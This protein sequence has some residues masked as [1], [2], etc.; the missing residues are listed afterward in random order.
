M[1]ELLIKTTATSYDTDD[2]VVIML[3]GHQWGTE[4]LN[5]AKFRTVS[6][7]LTERDISL[8][9]TMDTGFKNIS[10]I[11]Q[12]PTFRHSLFKKENIGPNG[13][14]RRYKYDNGVVKK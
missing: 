13:A 14:R 10:A 12:L 3:D 2:V 4:E 5:P 7:V 1:S 9:K 8:L 6:A 11:S